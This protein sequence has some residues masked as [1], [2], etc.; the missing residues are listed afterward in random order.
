MTNTGYQLIRNSMKTP[1]GSIYTNITGQRLASSRMSI[2]P[3]NRA[4]P[5]NLSQLIQSSMKRPAGSIYTNITGQRIITAAQRLGSSS[6][7]MS[8]ITQRAPMPRTAAAA[9]AATVVAS[10]GMTARI[11]SVSLGG[12]AISTKVP[13]PGLG[14]GNITTGIE[15]TV[16]NIVDTTKSLIPLAT[17]IIIGLVVLKI[18]FWLIRGRR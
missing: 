9:A 5:S 6:V 16:N 2:F 7:S 14:L 17:K 18:G 10:R 15:G 1:S 4:T 8:P 3:V 13:S 11:P 12:G